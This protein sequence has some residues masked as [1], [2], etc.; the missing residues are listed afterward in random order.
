MKMAE[1]K[2]V[3]VVEDEEIIRHSLTRL[4]ERHEYE[5]CEA[6]TVKES[7]EKYNMDEFDVIIS[8]LRLP[9]APGTDLLKILAKRSYYARQW[10]IF[11]TKYP[12]I[13][14]PF[15]PQPFFKPGRDLEGQEGVREIHRDGFFPGQPDLS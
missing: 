13:L 8:D 10:S 15:L 7:V 9:G 3:L 4:L 2:K 12:L 6:G 1:M 14:C 5:V 11:L